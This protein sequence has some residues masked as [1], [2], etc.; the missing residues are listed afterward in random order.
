[1]SN[2]IEITE[3][4]NVDTNI[5]FAPIGTPFTTPKVSKISFNRKPVPPPPIGMPGSDLKR[6]LHYNADFSGCG[7]WRLSM[8]EL[9]MNYN[10]KMIINTLTT[11]VLDPNFYRAGWCCIKIQRQATPLQ[12]EFVKFIKQAATQFN[13]K[14]IYEVDDLIMDTKIPMF[15]RC[16]DAFVD[17]TIQDSIRKIIDI[18]GEMSVCSPYMKKMYSEYYNKKEVTC[19]PNYAAKY[20]FGNRYDENKLQ[21]NYEKNKKRPRILCTPSG[22][23]FDVLNKVNQK[24][25]YSHVL[26]AIIDTRKDFQWVFMGG[27]PLLLQPF[28]KSGDI[29][30]LQWSNLL[31]FPDAMR[32]ANCQLSVAALEDNDFNKAKSWIK[33]TESCH[34]GLPFVGQDLEPYKNSSFKFNT[35]SEMIDQ[36]KNIVKDEDYFM[37][38]CRKAYASGNELWLDD[39]LEEHVLLYTTK[40]GDSKRKENKSLVLNNPEQFN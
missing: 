1:M 4:Y 32:D 11:M 34:L 25:D 6:A 12:L 27:M 18:C 28:V 3:Y 31:Q 37:K 5:P 9:L 17:P 22:T 39:H 24:D 40:Y 20:W 8:P 2:E 36:I 33:W 15:N 23:H 29:E 21:S 14:V 35:G 38:Q 26:Q 10:Q 16:R 30:F 13:I 19:V 7:Y